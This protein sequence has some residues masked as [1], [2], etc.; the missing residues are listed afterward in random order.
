MEQ[1]VKKDDRVIL[2]IQDISNEGEGV[3]KVQ[4]FTL[5]VPQTVT[6]DE[7]EVL[8]LKT[9]KSYG[10][11]QLL[12]LLKPSP[13]RQEPLCPVA[14][15]CGGCQLQHLQYEEQ[16]KWKTQKVREVLRRIGGLADCEVEDT[17]GMEEPFNYRNKVQYPIRQEEGLLKIGFFAQGTH[18][19]VASEGCQLQNKSVQEIVEAVR[20]YLEEEQVSIYNETTHK[21]LVRHLL[22]KT[23][24]YTQDKMVGLVI[25][26]QSIPHPEKLIERL[27]KIEGVRSILLNHQLEK[28]PVLLGEEITLLYGTDTIRDQIGQLQFKISPLSFFQ[29]NPT[30]T[31]RLYAKVLEFAELTGKETV[32][33]AYCGMGTISLFLAQ[34]AKAV[35]GVEIVPEAIQMAKENARLNGI[36]NATFL[37]GKA[38][39][40]LPKAYQ[41]G[42]LADT[43]VVDPPRKGCDPKLLETLVA[44]SPQKIVYVSCDPATLARDLKYLTTAGYNVLKVQPVDMFPQTVHVETV[45]KLSR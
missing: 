8:V 26:G 20:G 31:E 18:R 37:V 3:G 40:V 36:T 6:G 19:V 29:V 33:D 4:D 30:Q 38:E 9:K 35:Y 1:P 45:V 32:W 21:G 39:E 17:L 11:G 12:Q 7:V 16:L 41:E 23:A 25:N 14:H 44:M 34:R 43:V 10:Y 15:E 2:T 42:I 13:L 5:F 24:Y 28:S 27:K 22:I